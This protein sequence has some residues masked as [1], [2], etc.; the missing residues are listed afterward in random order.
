MAKNDFFGIKL[1][2]PEWLI[3]ERNFGLDQQH[4]QESLFTLGNGF[5]GSRGVLEEYPERAMPGTFIT[6][7]YDKS[8]AQVEELVNLPSPIH[9]MIA[10]EGEKLD[11]N[12]MDFKNHVRY[13][14]MLKGILLR[15][16]VFKDG[17]NRKFIYQSMRFFSMH[18]PYIGWMKI[19]IK[20]LNS[21]A[22]LTALNFI[23]DAVTN[24]GG[25]I[26][27][28]RRHIR[29]MDVNPKDNANYHAYRT[30]TS[31]IWVAYADAFFL[32]RGDSVNLCKDRVYNFQMK[33]GDVV[34]FTKAFAVC[35]SLQHRPSKIKETTLNV[36]KEAVSGGF[37]KSLE[38]HITA[39]RDKWEIANINIKGC[40]LSERAL[41]FNIYHLIIAGYKNKFPASITA[42]ALSGQGYR[43]HIFWD[44]EI[45]LLPFYLHTDTEIAKK[46]L[47]Y[48]YQRL[49]EAKKNAS[50]RGWQGALFPWESASRGDDVTPVYAKD[51]DGRVIKVDTI[52]FEQHISADIAFAVFNYYRATADI[53]FILNYGME[54]VFETAKF[55]RSR[56]T[57]N[58]KMKKYEILKVTGP[59][60]FH[61]CV[62]NNVY[63]N[64]L[65]AWNLEYAFKLYSQFKAKKSSVIKKLL[66]K[67]K[68]TNKEIKQWSDIADSVYIPHSRKKGLIEQFQGYFRKKE[69]IIKTYDNNFMPEAPKR[70]S[71]EGFNKTQ[72]IK[73]A[74]LLLLFYLLPERFN[75]QQKL[76]NYSYYINKTL[77]QSS[78]SHSIHAIIAGRMGNYLRAFAFFLSSLQLD[79]KNLHNNTDGGMHM[80]NI[81]GCWQ[82]VI[83]GFAGLELEDE[84]I[85][86][87]PRLPGHWQSISFNFIYKQC[88]WH[89]SLS[90]S[91]ISVNWRP[92]SGNS[93]DTM[94]I[95]L[96]K[97]LY[98]LKPLEVAKID[99]DLKE[100]SMVSVKRLKNVMKAE[101][102]IFINENITAKEVSRFLREKRVASVPVVTANNEMVGIISKNDIVNFAESEN[103]SQLKA[104]DIMNKN[105]EYVKPEDHL[106]IA[107][108]IFTE[109]SFQLLPVVKGK[110]L[111]GCITRKEILSACLG[112]C[113]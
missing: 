42:R 46:M 111:V 56:L 79:L 72:Y 31:K 30:M 71:Y 86:V 88:L 48:R 8:G 76:K 24:Y 68:L 112:E 5:I 6:G 69:S 25:L 41:R 87:D 98:S 102:F 75:Q 43:G 52:E 82:A 89:F 67:I 35:T 47:L 57:F 36:L 74:D 21:K 73:Q 81:G 60:E 104:K 2:K 70:I 12:L 38:N 53:E 62:D 107:L 94:N 66:K 18:N 58:E 109:R 45:F 13:L 32:D 51:I 7:I 93:S 61:T 3:T 65:A 11:M 4:I 1:S 91:K 27:A 37:Q 113:Y 54:L 29:L 105:V 103:F 22:E 23:D 15:R 17:K 39:W 9:F 92:L 40:K 33:A 110:I 64:I 80:A 97:K 55:Y 16:T 34:T 63:T 50:K 78:L 90:N 49:S 83:F 59:D 44:A 96:F 14:D 100:V 95:K 108:R 106:E 19:S 26:Y 84:M 85:S 20:L 99:R 10:A 28:N 77:H 101:N